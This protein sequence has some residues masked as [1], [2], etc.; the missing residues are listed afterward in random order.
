MGIGIQAITGYRAD[1]FTPDLLESLI[2]ESRLGGFAQGLILAD[3]ITLARS[4]YLPHWHSDLLI[5][6]RDG[7]LRWIS[8]SSVEL[9]D[10]SGESTGSIGILQDITERR[11]REHEMET[12]A[13]LSA[14]L[15]TAGSRAEIVP[16]VV[17]QTIGIL[18]SDT[19]TFVIYDPASG[20][21]H[22]ELSRGRLADWTGQ[23]LPAGV[24]II[25]HVIET[26]SPYATADL[27][28][29]PIAHDQSFFPP[30]TSVGCAPLIAQGDTIGALAISRA[31]PF[32]ESDMRI[33]AAMADIAA[34]AFRRAALNAE[35]R[36]R[37]DQLAAVNRL[38]RTLSETFDVPAIY[39]QVHDNIFQLIPDIST[40][41]ISSFDESQ[42]LI[43]CEYAVQDGENLDAASL[44]PI[45]LEP[46]GHGTQSAVI[47]SRQ[48]LIVGD[49]NETHKN[50]RS[51]IQVG[52]EGETTQSALL[53]PLLA[54][55]AVRGVVQL[56]SYTPNRFTQSDSEILS[57]IANT[58]AIAIENARLFVETQLRLQRMQALHRIDEAVSASLDLRLTL[59]VLLTQAITQ[60]GVNAACV[61]L[62]RAHNQ[63]LEFA[64]G[65]GFRTRA[66][67]QTS[68]R[69]GS[70]V[71]GR[72]A[73]E[74]HPTRAEK[75]DELGHE[76][77]R[78]ALLAAD[79]N[80]R[81]VLK[82]DGLLTRDSRMKERKKYGQPGARKRFQYSK[83]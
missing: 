15:R 65:Q 73:L 69:L 59:N 39:R 80:L 41:F 50:T 42:Q 56:Q 78:R 76:F 23:F 34:N 32:S 26:G 18:Q 10:E 45:P 6:T 1:E 11:Q 57:F 83:R 74:R 81:P 54:K 46:P 62:V 35:T 58:A 21:N 48:P 79:V 51:V 53:A 49:L 36:H 61:L 66:I 67:E 40:L 77:S 20:K 9:I 43:R 28:T 27:Q 60:L 16:I 55:G 19:A 47:H 70:D 29:D 3:A 63:A 71:T 64:A 68:I 38:G 25:G 75:I 82:K 33:L 7:S 8:D 5:R 14:R 4:G 72:A 13:A 2:I 44:P 52:T 37:A 30:G 22:V 12:I 31:S 17:D 24:G